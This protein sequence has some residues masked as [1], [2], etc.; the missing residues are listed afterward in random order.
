MVGDAIDAKTIEMI[1]IAFVMIFPC[2]CTIYIPIWTM[3][4]AVCVC[5]SFGFFGAS[6]V[7]MGGEGKSGTVPY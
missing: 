7:V 6:I 1:I 5:L 3:S 2:L 4:T